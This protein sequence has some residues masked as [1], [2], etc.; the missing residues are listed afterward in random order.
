MLQTLFFPDLLKLI[1]DAVP[2]STARVP[3]DLDSPAFLIAS[4][5]IQ[6]AADFPIQQ[7]TLVT[8]TQRMIF[9]DS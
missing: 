9:R 1:R 3:R 8:K 5:R 6:R 4:I 7:S 2:A